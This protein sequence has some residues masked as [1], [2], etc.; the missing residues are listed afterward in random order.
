MVS[1]TA[2][3]Y[4]VFPF[5][6]VSGISCNGVPVFHGFSAIVES[7]EVRDHILLPPP[8][9]LMRMQGDLVSFRYG[10]YK[11][12]AFFGILFTHFIEVSDER[13]WTILRQPGCAECMYLLQTAR[14]LD[15]V[16]L[17][18]PFGRRR[19]RSVCFVLD[20]AASESQGA[21]LLLRESAQAWHFRMSTH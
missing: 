8:P 4:I 5:F 17:H 3:Q 19:S 18:T 13:F 7:K 16:H 10:S 12:D 21:M 2:V 14:P 1:E 6:V 9:G 15:E 20:R 11:L